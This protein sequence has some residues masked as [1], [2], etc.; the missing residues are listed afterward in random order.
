MFR[1]LCRNAALLFGFGLCAGCTNMPIGN[2]QLWNHMT[3]KRSTEACC[4]TCDCSM[5]CGGECLG[6]CPSPCGAPCGTCGYGGLVE[7]PG[8]LT[9]GGPALPIQGGQVIQVNPGVPMGPGSIGPVPMN[10][11][12]P[13]LNDIPNALP[14]APRIVPNPPLP[15]QAQ[16][17]P[18]DSVSRAKTP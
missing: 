2:G 10:P 5:P 6:T 12:G 9:S 18:S 1:S 8:V 4:P 11:A 3:G 17:I 15:G 7:A 13:V 14:P 16:P